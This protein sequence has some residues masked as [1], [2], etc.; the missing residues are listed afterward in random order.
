MNIKQVIQQFVQNVEALDVVR[1]HHKS[2]VDFQP[3]S[4]HHTLGIKG[5]QSS[6]GDHMHD[7]RT[8]KKL[9]DPP[10][11]ITG[12]RG[13]NEALANLLTQLDALG[14]IDDQTIV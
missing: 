3:Q 4:Q 13:S 7:G 5:F 6:P 1:L 2:D 10:K 8:S 11:A 12:S 14:I 9:Y